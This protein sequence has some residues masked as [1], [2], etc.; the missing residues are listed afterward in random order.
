MRALI[1]GGAGFIGSAIVDGLLAAGHE[2]RVL[3][4]FSTGNRANLAHLAG[5]IEVVEGDLRS[6]ERVHNAV[7]GCDVVFHEGALPSVPRSIAD[8]LTSSEIN[9]GGTLNVLLAARDAGVRRVVFASSSSVYGDAPGFPRHESQATEPMAPYA[10]SK[11]A[12]EQYCRVAMRVYGLETVAL[13]YF[14]VFGPRQ[15][16]LSQYSA[17]I[18]K[19]IAALREG[20]APVI[21]GDGGQSRDFT[22]VSD[23]VRANLLAADAP[24]AA[25]GRVINVACGR[26][27]SL[28][29]LVALLQR[30]VGSDVEPEHSE[31]RPGDVRRSLADIALAGELL[32]FTPEVTFEEG[33][34]RTVESFGRLAP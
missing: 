8:P 27:H 11:L 25:A 15:D 12:A 5:D 23:V 30:L 26:D 16:P 19:F 28:N 13:R 4:N 17:V 18:P 3:D 33:L 31:A 6:Y 22:Y 1:T 29:E 7:A 21:H 2:P 20:S 14:N 10:V 24:V 32:A 34:R 9:I